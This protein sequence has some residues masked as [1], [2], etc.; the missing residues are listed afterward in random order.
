MS[1]T[2][3]QAREALENMDDYSRMGGIVPTGAYKVLKEF[4]EQAQRLES[5]NISYASE[6][7]NLLGRALMAE[8]KVDELKTK[9]G[10]K[11]I[12]EMP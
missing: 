12:G 3:E 6:N 4:I 7:A 9:N 2:I 8:K 5:A 10:I 11:T 1:I